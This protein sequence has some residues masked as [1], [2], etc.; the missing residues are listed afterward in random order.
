MS[1]PSVVIKLEYSSNVLR[2]IALYQSKY[3]DYLEASS[4]EIEALQD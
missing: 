3:D 4:K 1:D 2:E